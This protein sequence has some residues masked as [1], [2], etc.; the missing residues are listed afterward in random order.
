MSSMLRC[1][2]CCAVLCRAV[3]RRR[4]LQDVEAFRRWA[5]RYAR[6]AVHV[7]LRRHVE[8]VPRDAEAFRG[9]ERDFRGCDGGARTPL[10][11]ATPPPARAPPP[12]LPCYDPPPPPPPAAGLKSTARMGGT[13]TTAATGTAS[14]TRWVDDIG[15]AALHASS[16]E[17]LSLLHSPSCRQSSSRFRLLTCF[18][19]PPTPPPQHYIPTLLAT[20]S[21]DQE[22]SCHIDGV[23]AVDWSAGGPHPK[24]Y[25]WVSVWAAFVALSCHLCVTSMGVRRRT[26]ARAAPIRKGI[27]VCCMH[28]FLVTA[29]AAPPVWVHP[30]AFPPRPTK[31][32]SNPPHLAG[33]GRCGPAWCT[34][35]A[36][37]TR[38]AT[39]ATPSQARGRGREGWGRRMVGEFFKFLCVYVYFP[40]K[41]FTRIILL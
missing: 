14:L 22:S 23:V 2:L 13:V 3:V 38:G 40:T 12:L 15:T 41:V 28:C 18:C 39:Q 10:G 5:M 37:R 21:L 25:K 26:G 27:S 6:H 34:R 31:Q 35:R 1:M 17:P 4:F 16:A 32:P 9:G 36:A 11:C 19:H 8:V 24:S 7:M 33:L 20:H 30:S 29:G